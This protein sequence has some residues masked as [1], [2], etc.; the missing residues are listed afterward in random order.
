MDYYGFGKLMYYGI[1]QIGQILIEMFGGLK[2]LDQIYLL[3][4]H[5]DD[6]CRQDGEL[7][8]VLPF[9]HILSP[10]LPCLSIN[11]KLIFRSCYLS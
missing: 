7:H 2:N 3:G 9:P 1:L 4:G 6:C 8:P 10:Q 11:Q 5:S